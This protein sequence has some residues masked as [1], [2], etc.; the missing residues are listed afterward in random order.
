MVLHRFWIFFCHLQ[1]NCA[2]LKHLHTKTFHNLDLHINCINGASK[3]ED[4][5]PAFGWSCCPFSQTCVRFARR[6]RTSSW[7]RLRLSSLNLFFS[8]CSSSVS[9]A[10]ASN[11]QRDQ[12]QQGLVLRTAT[13]LFIKIKQEKCILNPWILWSNVKFNNWVIMKRVLIYVSQFIYNEILDIV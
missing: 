10:R 11:R 9:K 4:F 6:R 8:A 12:F 13:R 5:T 7:N 1:Y 3:V 2:D